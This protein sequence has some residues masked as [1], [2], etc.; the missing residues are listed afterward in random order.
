MMSTMRGSS[1]VVPMAAV[2]GAATL[3]PTAFVPTGYKGSSS[4]EATCSATW[5][6]LDK[7][8]SQS[9]DLPLPHGLAPSGTM[10]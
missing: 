7:Q 3:L 5:F 9:P 1:V 10:V 8:A 2:A 6:S 4:D